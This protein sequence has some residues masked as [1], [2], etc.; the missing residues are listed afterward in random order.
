VVKNWIE[1]LYSLAVSGRA[2]VLV[3]I[4]EARGSAPRGS[5]AKMVVSG[6]G[7]RGSVGGGQLE[8]QCIAA[9]T[10]MLESGAR[11]RLQKFVLGAALDQCCGG[12]VEVLFEPVTGAVPEW[13]AALRDTGLQRQ[14][15]VLAT[16][17]RDEPRKT[18]IHASTGSPGA[19]LPEGVLQAAQQML[20]NR[21]SARR[22]DD[23]L[24][25]NI[26]NMDLHIA[27]FGAG[28]VGSA[29]VGILAGLDADIRWIDD[30]ENIFSQVP[31]GVRAIH[32]VS[33]AI[34]A[35]AMPPGSYYLVMTHSHELDLGICLAILGRNDA[36]YC[37]LI[38]SGPK[39]RGF[40]RRFLEHGLDQDQVDKLVCPIGIAG[41]SG[42]RPAE[43]AIATAAEILQ[44]YEHRRKAP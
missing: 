31:D 18:L 14:N 43:I 4:V 12:A 7:C 23:V 36:A 8:Y 21:E 38:G 13:L 42:K 10:K 44:V 26:S 40:E 39:R 30:R 5:G 11:A 15:A 19:S 3:T 27:V 25:E 33:P 1:E 29:L 2:A 41:I 9:A 34:E 32:A 6:D 37:G 28:H 24:L 35:A 17:L 16:E 22:V 20:G